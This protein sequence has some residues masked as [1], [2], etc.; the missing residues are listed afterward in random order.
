M[1][2]EP[3]SFLRAA[4]AYAEKLNWPV[5]PLK[6]KSKLPITPHG[7]KDATR[8][9]QIIRAWWKKWP[10]ANVATPTGIDHWVLDKDMPE[11]DD[12]LAALI[13]RHGHLA[14]TLQQTTGGGGEQYFYQLSDKMHMGCH[15]AVWPGIDVKG[16]GGYVVLPPSVHPETGKQYVWDTAKKSILEEP[17]NP[18]NEWLIAEIQIAVNGTKKPNGEPERFELPPK[19]KATDKQRH[20]TLVRMAGSMRNKGCGYDEILAAL[21]V[22]NQERCEPPYDRK[23]VEQIVKWVCEKPPGEP[24]VPGPGYEPWPTVE[25]PPE[26]ER[27]HATG[28]YDAN[29]PDPEPIIEP[30][31]Y[32]GLTILGGRPK[33]GKSWLA[34]QLGIAVVNQLKL[35]GYLQ[36]QKKAKV[37]YV[38]L[39]DRRAQLKKRLRHLVVDK[40]YLEGLDLIYDIAPLMAGG[41]AQ[42][43][44]TL[45]KE[46]VGV[47]IVDSLLAAV[48][49]AGR[50]N[51]DV[52]QADYNIIGTLRELATKHAIAVIVVAHTRKMG[53]DFLD[54]IQGTSGTTA[55]ADAVWVLQRSPDNKATLSVTGRE[56]PTNTFGLEHSHDSA[57]WIITGEGDAVTQS[58][59]RQ[60]ILQLLKDKDAPAR[61]RDGTI[62]KPQGM[63]P[64]Q[65]AKELH[66]NISGINRLLAALVELGLVKKIGYGSYT[67]PGENEP[68][69]AY[70]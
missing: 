36:V 46:P 70:E 28:V 55:A 56:V 8:D 35:G 18:A 16:E 31:L 45:T 4:L 22:I 7:F 66:K 27:E 13:V 24:L 43:D 6:P 64:S 37:L 67:L 63:K 32:P 52:M 61:N 2:K 29:V 38:S 60:D 20:P 42:I 58:D 34:L 40:S 33:A 26:T 19:M 50:K 15:T 65:I 44:Q 14:D 41:A 30:I 39:E 59:A 21:W 47:L 5:F 69:E 48:K 1:T 9:P 17:I 57:A 12:S 23:H 11:G 62:K 3:N 53:G 68:P 54:L 49:A 10:K 51:V 25:P